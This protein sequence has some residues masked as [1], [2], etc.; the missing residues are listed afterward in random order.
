MT[1]TTVR[2]ILTVAVIAMTVAACS[3]KKKNDVIITTEIEKKAPAAPVKMQDYTQ[4]KTIEWLGN[5]YTCEV[6]RTADDS[7]S[8]V[9]DDGGQK[10]IDNTIRLVIYR[11]DGSVFFQRNFTKASF[12]KCLDDDYRKTGILEGFV[13]DRVDNQELRFAASVS[14][15]Q[16]DEY[17]PLVVKIS[18]MGAVSISRDTVE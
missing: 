11:K 14:H 9:K 3:E 10:Y 7:L 8:V 5:E 1:M 6:V 13:F 17:I 16:T 15:P 2:N 18:R 12:D 4:S